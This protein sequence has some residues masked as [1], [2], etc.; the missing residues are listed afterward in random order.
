MREQDRAP[1]GRQYRQL[2][3]PSAQEDGFRRAGLNKVHPKY[4]V[5]ENERKMFPDWGGGMMSGM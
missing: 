4:I 3:E 5:N 2:Q 1:V